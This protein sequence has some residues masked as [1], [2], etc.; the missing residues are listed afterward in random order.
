M[1]SMW[2][3]VSSCEAILLQE[4]LKHF[5]EYMA[6]RWNIYRKSQEIRQEGKT[7][8][9]LGLPKMGKDCKHAFKLIKNWLKDNKVTIL[10]RSTKGLDLET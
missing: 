5:T 9:K 4:E 10:E 8:A 1:W 3:A 6:K 7:E 2:V